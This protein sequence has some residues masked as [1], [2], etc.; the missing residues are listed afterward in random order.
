MTTHMPK[1][2][3]HIIATGGSIA[4]VGPTVWT[5]SATPRSATT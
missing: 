3:V 5:T 1:P 4:G 2:T